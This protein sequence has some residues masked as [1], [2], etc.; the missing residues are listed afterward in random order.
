MKLWPF[1]AKKAIPSSA[2]AEPAAIERLLS[3]ECTK[4]VFCLLF[5]KVIQ[6]SLPGSSVEFSGATV[7]RVV[8]PGGKEST[9][10][11]DN[12]WLRYSQ[13]N[14]DRRELIEKYIRMERGMSDPTPKVD[15]E[16][17]V[18]MIKDTEYMALLTQENRFVTDHLCGDLYLVYATDTPELTK[19][20]SPDEM[21]SAGVT[22]R[23]IRGLAVANLKR[24]LPAAE[25]HGDGPW[26]LVT[27][28]ADYVASLLLFDDLW[29]RLADTVEGE[30]VA[31]VPSRDVLMYTGSRSA[32]G[33]NAI[34]ERS[35][36]ISKTGH[37]AISSSL[38]VRRGNAWSV[39]QS[40]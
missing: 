17:I 5:S 28:G 31:T 13:G 20:L 12:L 6:E 4:E 14:E 16:N 39:F 26:Y 29:E 18:A 19:S 3:H 36:E 7:L 32:E 15:R 23:E 40:N 38:I 35:A 8:R 27:A 11:L 2:V 22:R 25:I 33:L 10:Y 21:A 9:T 24:L 34:R 37:H 30:I 1:G